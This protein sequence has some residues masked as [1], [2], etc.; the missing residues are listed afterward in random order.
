MLKQR[1]KEVELKPRGGAP[2][3]RKAEGGVT[4]SIWIDRIKQSTDSD[5][6]S[7]QTREGPIEL[8]AVNRFASFGRHRTSRHHTVARVSGGGGVDVN[9][10]HGSSR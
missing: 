2:T 1:V 5:Q 4:N 3:E 6:T 7:Q 9:V 8:G 10:G